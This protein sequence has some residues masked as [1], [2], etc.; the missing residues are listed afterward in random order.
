[1][2][3]FF[4]FNASSR[5]LRS[6][7]RT[8]CSTR[9][10]GLCQVIPKVHIRDCPNILKCE[11][12]NSCNSRSFRSGKHNPRLTSAICRCFLSK[13]TMS[14]PRALPSRESH[15]TGN[16]LRPRNKAILNAFGRYFFLGSLGKL[17][18]GR[19]LTG[20]LGLE[21][22]K[23]PS[24]LLRSQANTLLQLFANSLGILMVVACWK[25]LKRRSQ[26]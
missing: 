14:K 25:V 1:M 11:R 9:C 21:Q 4:C 16:M 5:D 13:K 23:R 18:V 24:V 19:S 12:N 15:G 8:H 2:I 3:F 20:W 10:F 26:N 6:L 7:M 17:F 22:L